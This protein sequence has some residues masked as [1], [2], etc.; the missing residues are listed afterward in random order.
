MGE[1]EPQGKWCC[2]GNRKISREK[3]LLLFLPDFEDL[4]KCYVCLLG[5]SINMI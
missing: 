2:F 5:E 4:T 3:M 1:V